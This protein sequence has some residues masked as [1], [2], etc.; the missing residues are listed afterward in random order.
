M[1]AIMHSLIHALCQEARS[2]TLSATLRKY[3]FTRQSTSTDNTLASHVWV[4]YSL[5]TFKV[6]KLFK[7][8][9]ASLCRWPVETGGRYRIWKRFLLMCSQRSHSLRFFYTWNFFSTKMLWE[10][11]HFNIPIL[12]PR[13]LRFLGFKK[14]KK[15]VEYAISIC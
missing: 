9:L 7:L 15:T 3:D 8:S 5:L 14:K 1:G 11:M 2:S 13:T 4:L 6:I 12:Q 10:Y